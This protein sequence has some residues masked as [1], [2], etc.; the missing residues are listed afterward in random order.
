MASVNANQSHYPRARNKAREPLGER[1]IARGIRLTPRRRAL[2]EILEEANSHLDA[3][4][5]LEAAKQRMRIDRATVYRTLELLKKQGLV[6]EL[7]LMHL[8]GEMHY[9]E[10]RNG[11]DEHFH[12]ACLGC[13]RIEE[14]S[15]PLFEQL[16]QSVGKEKGFAIQT[17]RLEIGGYCAG[18]AAKAGKTKQT[19]AP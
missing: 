15:T 4:G 7:D 14:I 13:G 12:L 11:E 5:L 18:C 9:Y 1:L 10:V 3:A 2:L 6:D 16:K 19:Q 8:R 17:A